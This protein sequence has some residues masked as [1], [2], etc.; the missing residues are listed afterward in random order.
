MSAAVR[1]FASDRACLLAVVL[2]G[3]LLAAPGLGSRDL[4]DPDEPRTAAVTAAVVAGESWAAPRLDGRPWLEKP[5][6]YYWLAAAASRAAGRVDEATVRLPANAAA[7]L[8]A[9]VVFFLGRAL[10]GR[11]A[12]LLA[13]IVLLTTFDFA[14]EARWARPDMLLA[15]FLT[16]AA[17]AAWKICAREGAA[18]APSAWAA[19]FWAAI[20][21]GVLTKGPV[22]L[23]PIAGVVVFAAATR[24]GAALRRLGVVWGPA[25]AALPIVAWALAWIAATG[26][27]FP[28]GEVLARFGRRITD[29]IHHA[30]PPLHLL[31]TLPLALLPWIALL[32]AAIAETW[33]RRSGDRDERAPFVLS[34]LVAY[35]ALFAMSAEK[36][37]VYLLPIVPLA[38]ILI[39]RLW[40]VRLYP[41]IPPPPARAIAAGL[42]A[43]LMAV[44]AA[45]VWVLA[46][47]AAEAPA[48]LRPAAL[49][50][51]VALAAAVAPLLLWRRAGA[52]GAV[53]L[54][55]AG[56]ALCSLVATHA[57]LPAIEPYKSPRAF[58]R[59]VA[60]AAGADPVGIFRDPHRG[61]AWYAGRPLAVLPTT[62]ALAAFLSDPPRALVISEA[63][64][65][66]AAAPRAG[67]GARIVERGRV[68]HRAFVLVEAGSA[69][70]A[71]A[72]TVP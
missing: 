3:L 29:G 53:G 7:I 24:R 39:G 45:A 40:D 1:L 15:L 19:A 47:L 72:G 61:I 10:W 60:A 4:W 62:E 44:G 30:R 59:R 58:G 22:A 16:F 69:A 68:G 63:Q 5:P 18:R 34:L 41:W 11:R 51:A 28:A 9:V 36:R 70:P 17:L 14:I 32:P 55:A 67:D 71:G 38:A 42:V 33:P 46:R 21:L 8:C 25:V 20:G 6:L 26:G 50:T 12:G 65:W 23:L 2:A 13:A 56:A 66:E 57:V 48:L 64:A 54:F 49:L 37:G 27:P 35:V 31:T 43:W 52:G